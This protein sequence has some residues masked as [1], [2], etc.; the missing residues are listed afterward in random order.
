MIARDED[1]SAPDYGVAVSFCE[2]GS[3]VPKGA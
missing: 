3:G 1:Y 2:Q